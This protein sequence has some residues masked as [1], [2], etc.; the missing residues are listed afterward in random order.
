MYI[1][2]HTYI[3]IYISKMEGA[4]SAKPEEKRIKD[5]KK[6]VRNNEHAL[7]KRPTPKG[8]DQK[9]TRERGIAPSQARVELEKRAL[10]TPNPKRRN[11]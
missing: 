6:N 7:E 4:L 5:E 9:R 1:Y 11:T 3:P 10:F 8:K 2:I